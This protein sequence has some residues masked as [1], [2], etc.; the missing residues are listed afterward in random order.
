M[1]PIIN[2]GPLSLPAPSLI[3][4]IGFWLGSTLAEKQA[5][6]AGRDAALL[7][8]ILLY[9]ITAGILGARLSFITRNPA[10]FLGDWNSILSLNPALLDP[11]GGLVISL[12]VIYLLATKNQQS[13]GHL[14][15]DLV[16]FL[17]VLAPAFFLGNFASGS[18]F[19]MLTDLPWGLEQWGGLR[20][21]VQLYYLLASLVVLYLVTFKTQPKEL[22]GSSLFLSFFTYS[23]GYISFIYTFQDPQIY[24]VGGFRVF[25]LIAWA[26]FTICIYLNHR[27]KTKEVRNATK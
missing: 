16:P 17:A 5:A 15:D 18:G 4:I 8:K 11:L 26:I 12:A 6:K 27:L 21:P 14:L 1:F 3:L 2:I 7:S 13:I 25:Q 20:H 19:G 22:P 10:A 9:A 24:T 23:A